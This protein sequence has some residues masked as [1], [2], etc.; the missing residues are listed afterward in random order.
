MNR[1]I[2]VIA[3][4]LALYASVVSTY[5]LVDYYFQSENERITKACKEQDLMSELDCYKQY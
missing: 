3:L 5:L 4:I 2:G 1:L